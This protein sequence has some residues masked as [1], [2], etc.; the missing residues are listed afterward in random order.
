MMKRY[1]DTQKEAY[2]L[3]ET[4]FLRGTLETAIGAEIKMEKRKRESDSQLVRLRLP[5]WEERMRNKEMAIFLALAPC[6]SLSLRHGRYM[7]HEHEQ[8]CGLGP[9]RTKFMRAPSHSR[10]ALL[11]V[12]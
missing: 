6:P 8:E 7:S 1:L 5:W 2:S 4:H 11:T 10:L 12:H 9:R 3:G